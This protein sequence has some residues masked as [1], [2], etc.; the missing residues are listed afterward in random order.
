MTK[1]TRAGCSCPNAPARRF[2]GPSSRRSETGTSSPRAESARAAVT[3]AKPAAEV[4]PQVRRGYAQS[5]ELCTLHKTAQRSQ[6]SKKRVRGTHDDMPILS[7]SLFALTTGL[8]AGFVTA[9]Y[10]RIATAAAAPCA[11][12]RARPARSIG[13]HPPPSRFPGHAA[14]PAVATGLAVDDRAGLRDRRRRAA[15][16][17]RVPRTHNSHLIGDRQGIAK[18]G[19]PPRVRARRRTSST[20]SRSSEASTSSSPCASSSPSR[21]RSES[22]A[23]GS[24]P[25]IVAVMGG[26]ELLTNT[27][28]QL[29]DRARPTFNPA[30]ATL[31]PSF[32][33]G[34]SA[35]AAA[36][37]ATAALLLGRW[38]AT[39]RASGPRGTRRRHR[40]CRRREPRAARRALAERRDRRTGAR[41]GLVRGL[42]DRVRRTDP[43]L[44]RGR[45]NG[46]T[47]NDRHSANKGQLRDRSPLGFLG[48]ASP[49]AGGL[50]TGQRSEE[51][52]AG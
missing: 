21:R 48:R 8:L 50:E 49:H 17:A 29:V 15:R 2:A 52:P 10:P 30:A 47:G 39:P 18:W 4:F 40:R 1:K 14:R 46:Q 44:R 22:G 11:R 45:G 33:S 28:K 43:P 36:F 3:A 23:S 19:Q 32:P 12:P 16:S 27:V 6:A 26:E 34:H 24:M 51:E 38:R 13:R 9:R 7:F 5:V 31:G 42:R 41:V 37:Y 20:R 35:T 25:F